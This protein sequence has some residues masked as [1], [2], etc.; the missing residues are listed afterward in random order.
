MDRL[1]HRQMV[2]GRPLLQDAVAGRPEEIG[3]NRIQVN[4]EVA[5][6][7]REV[8]AGDS[9]A[10]RLERLTRTV[11]VLGLSGQR[12]PAPVAQQL[13][14]E[15]AESLPAALAAASRAAPHG[16]RTG[17]G[18]RAGPADQ[19]R[20]AGFSMARRATPGWDNRWSASI[21][22]DEH[23]RSRRSRTLACLRS[24][25]SGSWP[26]FK[27]YRVGSKF[28]ALADDPGDKPFCE[29][30]E[31]AQR[32]RST[33]WRSSSTNCRTCC[34]PKAGARCCWCC[35]AWTPAAR[36]ARCAGC[37]RAPRRWGAR[38]RLQGAHR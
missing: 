30:S 25:S 37:S 8:W 19:A 2:L 20:P 26:A 3:K 15:T 38:R 33:R 28:Q 24:R 11:M 7:S 17:A 31:A 16:Q 27:K 4:G 21:D 5:K 6:A 14:E 22:P 12:G 29:G 13:Y 23:D 36:T 1:A 35:R 34:M 10:L 32:E 9:V 18:H